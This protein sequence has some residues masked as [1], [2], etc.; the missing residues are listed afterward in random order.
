[1]FTSC[2]ASNLKAFYSQC[3]EFL[4]QQL[5]SNNHATPKISFD[6]LTPEKTEK[7]FSIRPFSVECG[8]S[9][10]IS[11]KI[12]FSFT[13]PTTAFNTLRLLRGMQLRKAILLEG[14]PGVGKTSLVMTLAKCTNNKIF[15]IN[16]SDQTVS[17]F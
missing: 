12:Q 14:S 8:N 5:T 6:N 3:L 2:S 10:E 4:Y 9:C 1:M 15:R 17:Y 7:Y 13:A 11:D 16:L